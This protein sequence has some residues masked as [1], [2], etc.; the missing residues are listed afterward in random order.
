MA[1]DMIMI[2]MDNILIIMHDIDF[3]YDI[4]IDSIWLIRH[5]IGYA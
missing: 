2:I 1:L 3:H 5:G 4:T